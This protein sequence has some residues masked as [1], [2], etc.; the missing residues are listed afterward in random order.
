[1]HNINEI[2]TNNFH[3]NISYI[4]TN[5]PEL[6]SKLSALDSAIEHG[7]YREKYELVYEDDNFD[8]VEKSTNN[9]LYNKNSSTHATLAS[10]SIDYK[11]NDNLFES[12]HKHIISDK[13]L[14]RYE[15]EPPF[16]HPMSGFAPIMHYTQKNS[17]K[18]KTLRTIDKFIFFGV[19]LGLHISSIHKKISSKVYYIIE[20]DLE[21]FR[22]SLFSTNYKNI[23]TDATLI[24]SIFENNNEFLVSA[25]HFLETKNY[26]NHYIKYFHLLSHNSEKRNQFHIAIASQSHLLFFYNNL[27]T[28][29]LKPLDYLFS[30]YQFLNKTFTLSDKYFD[31]K[32]FLLIAAGPSLQKN[33]KWLKKNHKNFTTVAVSATLSFLEKENISP[34]IITH[35]DAFEAATVHFK[36]IK[37]FKFIKKSICFFSARTPKE[38]TSMFKKEQLFFFENGTQYKANSLKPSAPCI[39]SLS[40]QLL[41]LLKA[42]NIYLLGLDL[43]IDSKTGST[44]SGSHEYK[45]TLGTKENA[46]D[47]SLMTYKES[48]FEVA[49]NLDKKVLTTPHF[50]TSIFSINYFTSML[51]EKDQYIFNLSSGALFLAIIPVNINKINLKLNNIDIVAHLHKKCLDNASTNCDKND[52]Q[53]IKN[54]IIN[55]KDIYNIILMHRDTYKLNKKEYLNSLEA[56]IIKTTANLEKYELGRILDTYFNYILSYIFDFFNTCNLQ[57]EDFHIKNIDKLLTNHILDIVS[58]YIDRV[59][60]Y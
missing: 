42:K 15:K 55:A 53:N 27:L 22:L 39:G 24:F 16:E 26:Y 48:L 20:D 11:L 51:K 47:N 19:G 46:F 54:K 30:E 2:I 17:Q 59:E 23:A 28:Q 1:M 3:D 31:K 43:A 12:F 34:D 57:D 13:E 40:Y 36:K 10:K 8:V 56:L 29:Y 45:K 32:P 52:I 5:H 58:F 7:H 18:N 14:K 37:S 21:L 6:F 25:T 41:L 44:H 60:K 9:Y 4:Q 35:L 38:I 49:G 33:I 50:Q